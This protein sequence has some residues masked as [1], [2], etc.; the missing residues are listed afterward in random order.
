MN[1]ESNIKVKRLNLTVKPEIDKLIR[2]IA[3]EKG[4]KFSMVIEQGVLKLNG[5]E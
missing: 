1:T 4:W 5:G 2:K 3:K